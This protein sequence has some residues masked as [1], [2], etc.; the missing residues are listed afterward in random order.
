MGNIFTGV[1]YLIGVLLLSALFFLMALMTIVFVNWIFGLLRR[2]AWWSLDR[3]N[4][5]LRLF[6]FGG[7]FTG[8]SFM[9]LWFAITFAALAVQAVFF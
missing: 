1:R 7:A 3:L 4:P 5:L 2:Q 6:E 8:W 9:I